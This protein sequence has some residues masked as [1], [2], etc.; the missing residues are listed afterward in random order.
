MDIKWPV[1][2]L[3]FQVVLTETSIKAMSAV[4]EL[5]YKGACHLDEVI[6]LKLLL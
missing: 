5:V 2:N 3:L 6:F 4:K 1:K